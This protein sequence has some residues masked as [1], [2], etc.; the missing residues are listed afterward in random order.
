MAF[1][2][3]R[4]FSRAF[5]TTSTPWLFS[6]VLFRRPRP[7]LM[8]GSHSHRGLSRNQKAAEGRFYIAGIM[9]AFWQLIFDR[10]TWAISA[11]SSVALLPVHDFQVIWLI[12]S[13]NTTVDLTL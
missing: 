2:R 13:S 3:F 5:S 10:A 11:V 12:S 4:A 9:T 6:E 1:T 8:Q 7:A